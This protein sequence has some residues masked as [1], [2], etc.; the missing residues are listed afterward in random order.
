[1]KAKLMTGALIAFVATAG[2][3]R[4]QYC[5]I[6]KLHYSSQGDGVTADFQSVDTSTCALGV[7]TAVHVESSQGVVLMDDTCGSGQNHVSTD[8]ES[9][10][11]LAAVLIDVFDRCL[12]AHVLS[13]TGSGEPDELHLSNNFKTANLRAT[14]AGFDASNQPVMVA[15][16]LVWNGV[17]PKSKTVDHDAY[18][19]RI[20]QLVYTAQGTIR[21][22]IAAGSVVINGTD[23][24]P[25][26]ST[27]GALERD[28][29]REMDVYR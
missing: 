5:E 25:L 2:A 11:S 10:S 17:G 26:Q 18:N 14:V 3:A 4:A 24:T 22:A 8:T 12:G 29:T 13:V 15:I 28:A 7:V 19:E 9:Q 21:T 1:M 20:F 23:Q 16:D 27:R 6:E